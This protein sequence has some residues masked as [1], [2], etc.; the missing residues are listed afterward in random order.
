MNDHLSND[1]MLSHCVFQI[2]RHARKLDEL[3]RDGKIR[4]VELVLETIHNNADQGIR[5]CLDLTFKDSKL[6]DGYK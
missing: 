3:L 1:I 5:R 4:G 6:P 2:V